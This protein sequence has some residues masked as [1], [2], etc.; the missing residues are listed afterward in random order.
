MIE[1]YTDKGG[2]VL[3]LTEEF[4]KNA[5]PA[6]DV[7]PE[8]LGKKTADSLLKRKQGERGKQKSPLK[9]GVFARYDEYI[10]EYF[11]STGKGW[12]TRMN[13]ALGEYVRSH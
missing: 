11:K 2:E 4:F 13:D 12:Q 9:V 10:V 7:L 1:P 3:E 8:I 6:S 5:K